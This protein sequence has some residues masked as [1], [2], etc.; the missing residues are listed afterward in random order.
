MDNVETQAIDICGVPTP[1][2][3]PVRPMSFDDADD[4]RRKFQGPPKLSSTKMLTPN[5]SPSN[6]SSVESAPPAPMDLDQDLLD[7]AEEARGVEV[8]DQE[9]RSM[10][11]DHHIS[12]LI[13]IINN[14]FY[15]M[16]YPTKHH[17]R[18]P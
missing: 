18:L 12:N 13:P 6:A 15:F 14:T 2:P 4:R 8:L 1:S 7:S 3:V 10:G 17:H 5:P 11:L 9:N 16:V